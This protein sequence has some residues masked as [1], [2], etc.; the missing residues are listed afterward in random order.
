M[1]TAWSNIIAD[2]QGVDNEPTAGSN[3]LVNIGGVAEK[4]SELE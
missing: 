1:T 2:W 3:N 4:L